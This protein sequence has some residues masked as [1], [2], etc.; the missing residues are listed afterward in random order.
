MIKSS[1]FELNR[2]YMKAYLS[3]LSILFLLTFNLA[4]AQYT[5]TINNN[6]PGASQGAF[7]VGTNVLQLESGFALGKEKHR[8][9][10]T[11]TNAFTFDYAVRYGIWKEELEVSIMG[12]FQSNTITDNRSAF[13]YEYKE[14]N[15]RSNTIG[16][17]Y[18]FYDPYRKM[19]LEGPNLYSWKANYKFQWRDLIPA[20]SI[21]AG[22]NFD[23]ADNPF[24]P[25]PESSISP[26]FVLSTQNNWV[27][28]FVFVTNIIVDRITTDTPSYGYILTLTHTLTDW[29][30]VFVENQGIKSDFYADQLLRGG[31]ACLINK[32]LHVDAS[33]LLNFKDT[34][35]RLYGR[36]GLAYRFDMHEKDEFIEEK[37]K[38]GRKLKKERNKGEK[39][40]KK[41]NKKKRKDGFD[42]DGLGRG[43]Y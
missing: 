8:L 21:Y 14:S 13:P 24:T 42:D 34:P 39:E 4:T 7:S 3:C 22:A 12:E 37:G 23:F 9:R 5:E 11:E 6:R 30:S 31:A 17:K 16:A 2:I 10:Q 26:K 27:G 25:E 15:F 43:S 28:G 32:N 40:S 1:I 38:A 35:S 36:V 19:E 33:V 41:K 18:L 29:F 20:I